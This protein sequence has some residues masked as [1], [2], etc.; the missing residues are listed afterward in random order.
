VKGKLVLSAIK[1]EQDLR[2]KSNFKTITLDL[3]KVFPSQRRGFLKPY[4]KLQHNC[5]MPDS[6]LRP[7]GES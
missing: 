1:A 7:Y 3:G 4:G 6:A 2:L 5:L